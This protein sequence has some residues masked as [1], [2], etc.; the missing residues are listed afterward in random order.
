MCY[1]HWLETIKKAR[2]LL[3][4]LSQHSAKVVFQ[5]CSLTV[6]TGEH[7]F[8][9]FHSYCARMC[10][11]VCVCV[12]MCMCVCVC[13]WCVCVCVLVCVCVCVC[14]CVSELVKVRLNL[15]TFIIVWLNIEVVRP[16]STTGWQ[17]IR[18]DKFLEELWLSLEKIR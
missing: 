18:E 15:E 11:C 6:G 3:P 10:V 14:M 7:T 17:R 1:V 13:V 5:L 9:P 2:E 8:T 12:C 16:H 4:P